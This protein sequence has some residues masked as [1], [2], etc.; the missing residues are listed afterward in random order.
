MLVRLARVEA[1]HGVDP[2]CIAARCHVEFGNELAMPGDAKNGDGV[3]PDLAAPV[4]PISTSSATRS[5]NAR[6]RWPQVLAAVSRQHM[7]PFMAEG[8]AQ[9]NEDGETIAACLARGVGKDVTDALRR[10]EALRLPRT[11]RVQ[12][13]T[14][15]NKTRFRLPDRPEQIARDAEMAKGMTDWSL[16][17]VTWLYGHDATQVGAS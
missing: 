3:D 9:A 16:Q 10:Y 7:L 8:A 6:A 5:G 11:A 15:N 12:A 13:A 14:G 17:S 1:D 2:G 4:S